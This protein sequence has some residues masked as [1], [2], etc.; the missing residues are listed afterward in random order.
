MYLDDLNNIQI[1]HTTAYIHNKHA[2][3]DNHV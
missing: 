1:T 2:E 3:E